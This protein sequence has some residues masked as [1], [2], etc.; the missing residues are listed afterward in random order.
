MLFTVEP[1]ILEQQLEALL[2]SGIAPEDVGEIITKAPSILT[3]PIDL[4]MLHRPAVTYGV[5]T[6]P[7]SAAYQRVKT[8][9]T[10]RQQLR[11]FDP[12]D[13][14]RASGCI[15]LTSAVYRSRE[16]WLKEHRVPPS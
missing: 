4:S 1:V 5:S 8:A 13:E 7:L 11:R 16:R 6:A 12:A 3:L 9:L 14:A 2:S 15:L 10:S